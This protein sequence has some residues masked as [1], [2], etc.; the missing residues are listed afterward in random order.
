MAPHP[1]MRALVCGV[2][3]VI[4]GE[5]IL[6]F[7]LRNLGQPQARQVIYDGLTARAGAD[8]DAWVEAGVLE[9]IDAMAG[10]ALD[11]ADTILRGLA[12]TPGF[13]DLVD[14]CGREDMPVLL[15]GPVPRQF[16]E[17]L[18]RPYRWPHV[19]V[20]GSELR[21]VDGRIAGVETVCTPSRKR[22]QVAGWMARHG[23]EAAQCWAIGDASGDG[24]MLRMVPWPNRIS[25]GVGAMEA[26]ERQATPAAF[27]GGMAALLRHV[28]ARAQV[29]AHDN[30]S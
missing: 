27:T 13:A 10:C 19:R 24:D 3:R 30:F 26:L 12:L 1:P 6:N 15:C 7:V 14:W 9:K 21:I 4:T 20:A 28:Q 8:A 16:T 18:L 22:A 11:A 17:L 5:S 29:A 25:F 23:L 2:G